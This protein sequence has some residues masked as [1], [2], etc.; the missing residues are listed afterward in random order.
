M[1]SPTTLLYQNT[2][3]ERLTSSS[4]AGIRHTRIR[5]IFSIKLRFSVVGDFGAAKQ[6]FGTKKALANWGVEP[7]VIKS[8]AKKSRLSSFE[9]LKKSDET[10]VNKMLKEQT[11]A[12]QA[13]V[14]RNRAKRFQKLGLDNDEINEKLFRQD[15]I[16]PEELIELG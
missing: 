5:T 3:L 8:T 7:V 15:F 2:A 1:T 4:P 16:D 11:F 9:N 13:A 6:W 14:L 12:L 10:W